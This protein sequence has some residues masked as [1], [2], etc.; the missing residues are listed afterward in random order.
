MWHVEYPCVCVF[1]VFGVYS[2]ACGIPVCLCACCLRGVQC[3]MW[4]TCV[5]VCVLSLG[6]TVWHVEY[7]CVYVRVV[8]GVYSVACGIPVCMCAC[9]LRGVQ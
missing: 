1:V 7:L 9:C 4:N 3:G 5:S 6:C 8:F 2:V